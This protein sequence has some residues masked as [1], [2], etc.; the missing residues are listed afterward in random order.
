M[1]D[2]I[3]WIDDDAFFLNM[4]LGI[5]GLLPSGRDFLSICSSPDYKEMFT[6]VSSGQFCLKCSERGRAFIDAVLSVDLKAVQEWWNASLGY[7]SNGDQD[8]MVFLLKEDDCFK[9]YYK[10]WNYKKFNSRPEEVYEKGGVGDVFVLHFTGVLDKKQADYLRV[11][12]LLDRSPSLLAPEIETPYR[13]VYKSRRFLVR[14]LDF[15]RF[16]KVG[17]LR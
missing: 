2:Y 5:E 12:R 1:F 10:R 17:G 3:F 7:F 15:L 6:F 9:N 13:P 4:D 8:A 16:I 14:V 11:Q